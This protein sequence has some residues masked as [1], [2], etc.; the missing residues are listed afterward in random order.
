MEQLRANVAKMTDNL[1]L[2]DAE[3]IAGAQAKIKKVAAERD[4]VERQLRNL[5]TPT[6]DEV[7]A[8]TLDL[9]T[10][11]SALSYCCHLLA[12]PK[13]DRYEHFDSYAK[14]APGNVRR[15]VRKIDS[16]RIRTEVSGTG[17]QR[18]HLFL[19][20]DITF[21]LPLNTGSPTASPAAP[22]ATS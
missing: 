15:L 14:A 1:P 13:D 21:A 4:E 22:S 10:S 8:H 7:N 9:L 5:R 6:D 20:G 3:F 19:G 16:I 17:T 11:L 2:L 12:R 18:R